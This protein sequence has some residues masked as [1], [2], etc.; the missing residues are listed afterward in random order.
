MDFIHYNP[1]EDPY[2]N[3]DESSDEMD[4]DNLA[5][6]HEEIEKLV[7]MDTVI[8]VDRY[9][10]MVLAPIILDTVFKSSMSKWLICFHCH[11]V[12]LLNTFHAFAL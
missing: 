12:L 6:Q 1:S 11:K 9:C 3:Y 5:F 4:L 2:L 7:Y 10:T 8:V